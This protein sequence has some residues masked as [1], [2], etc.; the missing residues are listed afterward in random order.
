[1]AGRS[2][3]D[4]VG[5]RVDELLDQLRT[6]PATAVQVEEL[7]RLLLDLYG[8]ALSRVV[9]VAGAEPVARMAADPLLSAL[10]V[11]H[12]L[13]PDP[14]PV[15]IERALEAIRPVLGA[16]AGGVELLGL[17]DDGT[18]RL[19]LEG[20]CHHCPSS[21]STVQGVI[22]QAVLAAAPEATAVVVDGL[23]EPGPEPAFIPVGAVA[24]RCPSELTDV[25]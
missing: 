14:A 23:A 22:E 25:P 19:A 1:M 20:T 9:A 18:V 8:T 24:R 7:V 3:V 13:H 16:H 11:L 5:A 4:R 10:L 15:R 2:D 21:T 12:D 17:D 6:D